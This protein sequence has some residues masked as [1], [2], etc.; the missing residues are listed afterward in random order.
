MLIQNNNWGMFGQ[1]SQD[2]EIVL[3]QH[4]NIYLWHLVVNL[5]L[6]LNFFSSLYRTVNFW[7]LETFKLVSK[8]EK[9]TGPIRTITFHHEE[10][11]LLS[12]SHDSLKVHGWEPY[13]TKDTLLM[14]WGK[15]K[16]IAIASTQLV[17]FLIFMNILK[18]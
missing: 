13:E 10:H 14:G 17:R 8:S 11:C 2:R 18:F 3:I 15:I 4:I 6:K 7:D 5:Y 1:I 12:G 16:D 9:D